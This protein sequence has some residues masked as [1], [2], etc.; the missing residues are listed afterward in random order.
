METIIQLVKNLVFDYGYWTIG[1]LMFLDSANIPAASEVILPFGGY[2]SSPD[3]SKLNLL[4]LILLTTITTTLGSILNYYLGFYGGKPF[5]EKHGQ[6]IFLSKKDY[7]KGIEWFNKFGN[8]AVFLGR[9]I[10]GVRTFISFPAGVAKIKMPTFI[11]YTIAGSLI[12]CS[13]LSYLGYTLGS[14]WE[15]IDVYLKDFHVVIIAA[16]IIIFILYL[17]HKFKDRD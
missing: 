14:R 4:T 11:V 6:K 17:R 12:W 10:P 13:A 15:E 16:F 1:T 9:L 5:F 3:M 2:L 7:E 8:M